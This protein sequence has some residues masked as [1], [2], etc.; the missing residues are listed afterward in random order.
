MFNWKTELLVGIFALIAS[1]A[2]LMLAYKVSNFSGSELGE[3]YNVTAEFDNVGGLKVRSPVSIGGV[4]IG[5]VADIALDKSSF[6]PVVTIKI[7]KKYDSLP[8]DSVIRILTSGLLGT[9]YLSI[10][11][12]FAEDELTY[13][14][15]GSEFE[16]VYSAI[17]L[18][19]LIGEFL[20]NINSKDD[21]KDD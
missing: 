17:I 6:K 5:E 7:D 13:L 3:T 11:P 21:K 9:N 16:E 10:E 12:G 4:R 2:L 14:R 19:N 18:E 20:F 1:L 8:S 15:E